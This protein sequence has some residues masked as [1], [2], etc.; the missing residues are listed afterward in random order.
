[1]SR[2]DPAR[3]RIAAV[4]RATTTLVTG[5]RTL[6]CFDFVDL[7]VFVKERGRA[8]FGEGEAEGPDRA[9]RAAEAAIDDI[10]RQLRQTQEERGLAGERFF[11]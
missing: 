4:I 9:I 11:P 6:P 8:Y 7:G 1:V 3:D 5:P 10:R 2:H